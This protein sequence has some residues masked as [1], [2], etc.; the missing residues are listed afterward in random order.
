MI[1]AFANKASFN[2][3]IGGE[4]W[5]PYIGDLEIGLWMYSFIDSNSSLELEHVTSVEQKERRHVIRVSNIVRHLQD[6]LSQ[7]PLQNDSPEFESFKQSLYQ[8]AQKL[9]AEPNGKELLSLLGEIYI[10]EAKT[11]LSRFSTNILS[12]LF[13]GFTFTC[14]LIHGFVTI[15]TNNGSGVKQEEVKRHLIFS[16]KKLFQQ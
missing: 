2:C 6:K 5:K 12:N 10:S 8:E 11:H 13:N 16:T 1:L 4:L 15:K 14:D 3:Y 7:F 9:I